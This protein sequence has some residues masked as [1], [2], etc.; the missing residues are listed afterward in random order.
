MSKQYK[1]PAS[2]L[3]AAHQALYERQEELGRHLNY[4]QARKVLLHAPG[5]TFGRGKSSQDLLEDLA[6]HN[7][8]TLDAMAELVSVKSFD[9]KKSAQNSTEHK[10]PSNVSRC[11]LCPMP[12]QCN[13][14]YPTK[15]DR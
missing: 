7:F 6:K 1:S 15:R 8:V 3:S 5:F 14:C 9:E 11:D 12:A 4:K 13:A 2:H 10:F